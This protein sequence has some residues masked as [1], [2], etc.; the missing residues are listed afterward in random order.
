[1]STVILKYMQNFIDMKLN[2][3][4]ALLLQDA[5]NHYMQYQLG[6]NTWQAIEYEGILKKIE[7]TQLC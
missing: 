1:M 2:K 5:I 6:I 3:K 4:E 7:S